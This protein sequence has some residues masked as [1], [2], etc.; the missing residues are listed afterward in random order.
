MLRVN[1][2]S[3]TLLAA[4]VIAYIR[5]KALFT[6]AVRQVILKNREFKH[7]VYGRRQRLPLIIY[8]LFVNLK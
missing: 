3:G 1:S 8:S 5:G 2:S 4:M 6:Q 7:D